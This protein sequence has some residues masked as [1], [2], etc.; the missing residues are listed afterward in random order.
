M[1]EKG[2]KDPISATYGGSPAS[3]SPKVKGYALGE[4]KAEQGGDESGENGQPDLGLNPNAPN[5]PFVNRTVVTQWQDPG[6]CSCHCSLKGTVNP[7]C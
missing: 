1:K 3:S 4:G 7:N 6:R 5:P 2:E